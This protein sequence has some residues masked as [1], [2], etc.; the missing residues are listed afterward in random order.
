MK[1]K[2]FF[3][4]DGVEYY[5][6]QHAIKFEKLKSSILKIYSKYK[7]QY[8]IPPIFD[9][10]DNLL[11]LKSTDLD[12]QTTFVL[13]KSSRSE[14]GIRADITPQI[15][16]IDYQISKGK[17][18]SKFSYMGDILRL[19]PGPF[20]RLNPYQTGAE[21]FGAISK[22]VDV[23]IIKLMIDIISL[24]KEDKVIIELGDLS[25]VNNLL[26]ELELIPEEKSIL[27]DLINFKSKLEI[28]DFFK[29]NKLN[30]KKLI[31]LT[32]L[33]NLSGDINVLKEL[34]LLISSFNLKLTNE[35]N[36]LTAIA[37]AINKFRGISEVQIDLCELHGFNYQSSLIYAAYVPNLRK[38]V[39]RGGR[40]NAYNVTPKKTRL[41]TGFSLDIKD[42]FNLSLG[43][44]DTYV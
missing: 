21:F 9:S 15:S 11:N 41:A 6:P 19:S 34:K 38:E 39:A 37:K 29:K 12:S 14:V 8:I 5:M 24:S 26:N 25:F 32:E 3:I 43:R 7:Y 28:N 36:E 20:D 33:L 42:I 1:S 35:F 31:L 16:R 22:S 10:L 30:N 40:Y 13:D 2:N 17:A 23:E 27:I 18:N 44:R 4:P